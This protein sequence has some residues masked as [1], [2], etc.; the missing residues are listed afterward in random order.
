[1]QQNK[2]HSVSSDLA[3]FA[4][5]IYKK[6]PARN[7][8][9]HSPAFVSFSLPTL[10]EPPL[11]FCSYHLSLNVSSPPSM[12][13]SPNSLSDYPL[14]PPFVPSPLA[15]QFALLLQK[16]LS[17]CFFLPPRKSSSLSLSHSL[18]PNQTTSL[19]SFPLLLFW[20]Q[21]WHL[22]DTSSTEPG[23]GPLPMFIVMAGLGGSSWFPLWLDS[24]GSIAA[25][26]TTEPLN[27]KCSASSWADNALICGDFNPSVHF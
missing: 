26:T 25:A 23:L 20:T 12:V 5:R 1:M 22:G 6:G 9:Q 15:Y 16:P 8:G 18:S 13:V 4:I 21:Q 19:L 11:S 7:L 14:F 17:I 2:W 24:G 3:A 10:S 27:A